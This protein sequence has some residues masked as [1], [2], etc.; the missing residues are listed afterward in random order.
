MA[1][2]VIVS[3]LG[4]LV[5]LLI[6][7]RLN[8][9][10]LAMGC[11]IAMVLAAAMWSVLLWRTNRLSGTSI[12]TPSIDR[13]DV[14]KKRTVQIVVLLLFLVAAFWMTKS[15]PWAPRLIGACMLVLFMVGIALRKN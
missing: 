13:R 1:P 9:Q 3:I 8:Q 6:E 4:L 10:S 2:I 14:S 12:A 5:C 11:V 7:G 15:R